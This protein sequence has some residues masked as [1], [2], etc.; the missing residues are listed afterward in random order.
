MTAA[1]NITFNGGSDTLNLGAAQATRSMSVQV[2]ER[3]QSMSTHQEAAIPYR[4]IEQHG[5][6]DCRN[7][8]GGVTWGPVTQSGSSTSVLALAMYSLSGATTI[9]AN[10]N[11]SMDSGYRNFLGNLRGNG[12]QSC[13]DYR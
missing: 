7:S 12:R 2:A 10:Q 4:W 13:N 11:L 3:P 5:L 6:C 8:T 1:G 9:A